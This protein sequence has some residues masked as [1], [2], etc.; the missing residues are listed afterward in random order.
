[1]NLKAI[2]I[3]AGLLL[4]L[5]GTIFF[6]HLTKPKEKQDAR[7]QIWSIEE[8][9]IYRITIRLPQEH[10]A[11]TFIKG[12]D[13]RWSFDDQGKQP[14][15]TKRWG[16]IVALV[17][18]PKSKRLIAE[19]VKDLNE[20]ELNKPRMIVTLAI[21]EQKEPLEILF[22]GLTPQGDQYYVKMKDRTP[23]YIIHNTYCEVLMRL[24]LEPPHLEK[25]YPDKKEQR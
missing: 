22:G 6:F 3:L 21:K 17:S 10:K 16:G 25:G 4:I 13:E 19:Q 8:E 11:V 9:K 18:G 1:L 5:A 12:K 24:V 7:P 2:G 20:Y 14:V 15:D 23:V